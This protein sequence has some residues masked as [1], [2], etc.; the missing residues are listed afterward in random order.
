MCGR[1]IY[2][3]Q[4]IPGALLPGDEGKDFL[5]VVQF[6]ITQCQRPDASEP[7][8]PQWAVEGS[9]VAG[10]KLGRSHQGCAIISGTCWT[11]SP[12]VRPP[13][14][15][16]SLSVSLTKTAILTVTH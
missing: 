6:P 5:R 14:L 4:D 7:C 12:G 9:Y 1:G 3:G 2:L 8:S 13:C 11:A 15:G 10:C 16:E